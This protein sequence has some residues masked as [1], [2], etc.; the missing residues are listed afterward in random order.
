MINL[1]TREDS[2]PSVDEIARRMASDAW[3]SFR[4]AARTS[5]N[6][7][8]PIHLGP[9]TFDTLDGYETTMLAKEGVAYE[10]VYSIA[11]KSRRESV[12]PSCSRVYKRDARELITCG[13]RGGK[14]QPEEFAEHLQFFATLTA[15]SFGL[16]HHSYGYRGSL[17]VCHAENPNQRCPHGRK[18]TCYCH[19]GPKDVANGAPLCDECNDADVIVVWN[20]SASRLWARTRN[21]VAR[22]LAKELNIRRDALKKELRLEY[23]KVAEYQARGVVHFHILA[24]IDEAQDRS[25]LPSCNVTLS[26]IER[27]W[28]SAVGKVYVDATVSE[29]TYRIKW[30][31]QLDFR[32]VSESNRQRVTN[33]VAKYATKSSVGGGSFDHEF[34]ETD[35]VAGA[36][37]PEHLKALAKRAF[38][39]GQDPQNETLNLSRWAH[40]LGYRGHFLTKSRRFSISFKALRQI[41]QDYRREQ[42]QFAGPDPNS[43]LAFEAGQTYRYVASGW[44]H[45][46]DRHLVHEWQEDA[47]KARILEAEARNEVELE[48]TG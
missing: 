10:G 16:V 31:E 4:Q 18:L 7:S 37:G 2:R 13:L 1:I 26:Q 21:Y 48:L 42:A 11:C 40:D 34:H 25:R 22:E 35:D 33:Y 14:T 39:L 8:N 30:G 3:S 32:E 27:A 20:N 28:R 15:P 46:V 47:E 45:R 6:C 5:G 12:C 43:N 19:H 41:R 9:K 36:R 23:V 38:E 44:F 24:R 29:K 17:G